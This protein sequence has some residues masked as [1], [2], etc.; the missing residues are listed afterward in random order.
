MLYE[1]FS[2]IIMLVS[3]WQVTSQTNFMKKFFLLFLLGSTVSASFA[4]RTS[5]GLKGGVNFAKLS[6]KNPANAQSDFRTGFHAGL[7]AHVHLT[8]GWAVQPEIMYSTQGAE[9]KQALVGKDKIDYINVPVLIQRMF[10]PGFRL[11]TGPQLGYQLSA[12]FHPE[13]GGASTNIPNINNV[14]FSWIVGAGYLTP[15]GFGF[16]VRYNH[17]ISNVY[18]TGTLKTKNRVIQAGV[19]YQFR[20]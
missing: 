12:E 17:G 7:L 10:G 20:R 11:Q 6:Y 1:K 4:Q 9:Y 8:T 3:F 2:L 5:F 18:E 16:D 15:V 14:D 13:N 19:F